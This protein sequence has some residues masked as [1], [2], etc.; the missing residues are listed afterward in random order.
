MS[1]AGE[2]KGTRAYHAVVAVLILLTGVGLLGVGVWL[3]FT[4]NGDFLDLDYSGSSNGV[5]EA[6][7]STDIGAMVTGAFL[8][9]SGIISLIALTRKSCVGYTFRILY[10]ILALVILI[11]LLAV[12]A[13]SITFLTSKDTTRVRRF[14]S[15][16]W[17]NSV[18]SGSFTSPDD[19]PNSQAF[20][21]QLESSFKCRGFD[22]NDCVSCPTGDINS[23]ASCAANVN[24]RCPLCATIGSYDRNTSEVDVAVGCYKKFTGTLDN[25]FL[26]SAIVSGILS[27]VLLI[28]IFFT[29]CL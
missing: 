26:P 25:V 1:K 4:D 20:L 11:V 15:D 24:S 18:G 16:A 8:I 28:D 14:F 22:A 23:E 13:A 12:C 10:I 21:C 9:L 6:I 17:E 29:C 2:R 19:V 5:V 3:R 27:I 7:A